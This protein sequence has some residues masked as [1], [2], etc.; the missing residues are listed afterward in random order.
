LNGSD[1]KG[2]KSIT[3]H[4]L[5][6]SSSSGITISSSGWTTTVQTM[7]ATKKYLWN[8]ETVTYTDDST[9]NT[10]P[11]I[12]GVYGDKGQK[13]DTGSQGP[14]GATGATGATGAQGPQGVRGAEYRGAFSSN[15][16]SSL[17]NG[18]WYL[19]TGDGYCYYYTSSNSNWNKISSYSDYRYTQAMSDMIN[20][21]ATLTSN[22]NLKTA[23]NAWVQNLVA[24]TA[25]IEKLFAK[26]I[27]VGNEIK[28][29]NYSAGSSGFII[30]SDGN[31]EFNSGRFRGGLGTQK[32]ICSASWT[33]QSSPTSMS[34]YVPTKS[35]TA[36]KITLFL[37]SSL[38]YTSIP[39]ATLENYYAVGKSA[40]SNVFS[41]EIYDRKLT[42]SDGFISGL[43]ITMS[44]LSLYTG[45]TMSVT[46]SII[47]L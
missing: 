1:G 18:D 12:I 13:G 20:L 25:L 43:K 3:E 45:E 23:V 44:G 41:G 33:P 37:Y 6:T 7:T 10:S 17:V 28:S 9:T 26:S 19:K 8:Y 36:Q 47:D 46:A 29:S 40:N 15:P 11:S 2:I 38:S 39:I 5:V 27:S 32:T 30:S 24:G 31:A 14:K 34:G 21:S 16:T 4:Y 22:T 35:G 42:I